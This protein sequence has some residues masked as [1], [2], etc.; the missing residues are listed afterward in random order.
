MLFSY[1]NIYITVAPIAVTLFYTNT[2]GYLNFEYKCM[3]YS[4][5]VQSK[6]FKISHP[7]ERLLTD[8]LGFVVTLSRVSVIVDGV[9]IGDLIY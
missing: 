2:R 6:N 3:T 1:E 4:G 9:C 8:V 5:F 7:S